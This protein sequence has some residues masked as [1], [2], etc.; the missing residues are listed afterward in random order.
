[1]PQNHNVE[2][3]TIARFHE[4][5]RTGQLTSRALTQWYLDRIAAH[6]VD[7]AAINAVVTV[8]PSALA[9]AEAR[10][11]AFSASGQLTG[12]LHGV[13]ILVK[14]QAETAGIA[15]S[16]GSAAFADYI[17][18][19]DARVVALLRAAG[20]VI[21]A[22]TAMCDFAA[23]WFSSSSR[24]GH[25]RN[26]YD[27]A[28]DSGGSSAGTGAGVSADFGLVGVGE[29]T[30]GSIRIPASFNNIYGLRVTTGLISRTGFS[31]LVHFQDTPGPMARTVED[32][33]TLL[34]V[35]VGYDPADE[36]TA[37]AA[38]ESS[39]GGY[40]AAVVDAPPMSQW[41]VGVLET[42]FGTAGDA[43]TV[44][45]VVRDAIAAMADAGATIVEGLEIDGLPGWI[46]DTSVY[47]RQSRSDLNRFLGSRKGPV[48]S[49]DELTEAGAF[50]ELNDLIP[51]IAAG[52]EQ[53]EGDAEV[54]RLRLNQEHF[55]R[56]LRTLFADSGAALIVYPT[57]QVPAPTHDG[58]RSGEYTALTF[59]TNTVIAS[60]AGFPAISI[61]VGFTESGLA[62]GLEVLGTPF[63]EQRLLQ[64]AAALAP[65]VDA[66]RAPVLG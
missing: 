62:V 51:A 29:D 53:V 38:T 65:L 10:D 41:C 14:D 40:A 66:R 31:P 20:A 58:L 7:G 59:P 54:T 30:G 24:T 42:A 3:L 47:V 61:P 27:P 21:L 25:T 49:F 43:E 35:M 9:E 28:R 13:P 4:G 6:N 2:E 52:P 19:A 33:A 39:V 64:F 5:I 34:E 55:R 18:K 56:L 23:G 8:N 57:V 11:A 1:M 15:T 46:S 37:V 36:Y 60:Q 22:K 32:L 48:S 50:D 26:A 63:T 45:R 12:P 16:F 17:P 44:N